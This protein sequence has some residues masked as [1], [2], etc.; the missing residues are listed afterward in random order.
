MQMTGQHPISE[1]SVILSVKLAN[2]PIEMMSLK[3]MSLRQTSVLDFGTVRDLGLEKLV[4]RCSGTVYGVGQKPVHIV[5]KITLNIDIGDN[6]LVRHSF[7]VLQNSSRIRIVGRDLLSKFGST[8]LTGVINEY[9][10]DLSGRIHRQYLK[11]EMLSP[12]RLSPPRKRN[13]H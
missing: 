8:D 6:Q 3:R 7:G 4:N 1:L 5:G 13:S 11:A 2:T 10:W 9:D 12:D